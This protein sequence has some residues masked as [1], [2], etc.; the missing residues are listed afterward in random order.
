VWGGGRLQK[1]EM[2][3]RRCMEGLEMGALMVVE[4]CLGDEIRSTE[5]DS[6]T[7]DA[8]CS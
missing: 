7:N 4:L 8:R 6:M 5:V 1:M 3:G 2:D